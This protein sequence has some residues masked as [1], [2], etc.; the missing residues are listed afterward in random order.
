MTTV[1][2]RPS[3]GIQ[4]IVHRSTQICSKQ[5]KTYRVPKQNLDTAVMAIGNSVIA[6]LMH[7]NMKQSGKILGGGHLL[8]CLPPT[9][10]L[11]GGMFKNL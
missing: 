9:K 5:I 6:I 2:S 1:T 4:Y 11:A 8:Y 10:L 3:H 7:R